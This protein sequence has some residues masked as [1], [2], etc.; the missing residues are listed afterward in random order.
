MGKYQPGNPSPRTPPDASALA[1][2]GVRR[3][4]RHFGGHPDDVRLDGA[5]VGLDLLQRAGWGVAVEVAVEVD[6]VS[7]DADLAIPLVAPGRVDP[8]VGDV[9][10]YLP[11]PESFHPPRGGGGLGVARRT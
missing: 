7:D 4:S 6:L 8:G 9:R 3:P 10:L 11:L 5:D 2:L 1:R